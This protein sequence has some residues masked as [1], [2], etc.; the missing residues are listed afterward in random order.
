MVNNSL[1]STTY[2]IRVTSLP[3]SAGGG[4]RLNPLVSVVNGVATFTWQAAPGLSFQVQY[5]TAIPP[6]GVIVW[7]DV[8]GIVTSLTGN[9]SFT[10]DGSLTGGPTTFKIYRI[11]Q[12]P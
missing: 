12:L 11:V 6:D 10:D 4:L 9:Y 3:A 8:P 1:L 5:A 7:S 2:E